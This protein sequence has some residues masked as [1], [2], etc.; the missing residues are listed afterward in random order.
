MTKGQKAKRNHTNIKIAKECVWGKH[1]ASATIF[2]SA[3]EGF[4]YAMDRRS[5][6]KPMFRNS[7]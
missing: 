6:P 3:S 4:A 2:A 1:L 7:E 5:Y